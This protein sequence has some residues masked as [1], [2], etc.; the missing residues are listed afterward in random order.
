M[1]VMN[2]KNEAGLSREN[3][4][5]LVGLVFALLLI[6]GPV[7]PYGM[8]IRSIYL[9]I[10]PISVYFFLKYFGK[11]WTMDKISNDYLNRTIVAC[12][13]GALLVGAYLSMTA[14]YHTECDQYVRTRDGGEC[15]GDYITVKGSDK[16]AAFMQVIFAGFA[17][18]YASA[19]RKESD[20]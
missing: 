19:K 13:A 3:R 11:K 9:I 2:Y 8:I 7:E 6:F 1:N 14:N 17:I 15:V 20:E 10:I 4:N 18:W 12:I 5:F 16:S